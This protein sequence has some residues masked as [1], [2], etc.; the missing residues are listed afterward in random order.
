MCN[1]GRWYNLAYVWTLKI[2]DADDKQ[3]HFSPRV[4]F[5]RGGVVFVDDVEVVKATNDMW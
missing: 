4:D 3:W 5:G 1:G 2:K